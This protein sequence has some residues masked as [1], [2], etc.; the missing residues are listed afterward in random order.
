METLND[1][2]IEIDDIH[3]LTSEQLTE[4]MEVVL[5]QMDS[6]GSATGYVRTKLKDAIEQLGGG[7]SSETDLENLGADIAGTT[8]INAT[9]GNGEGKTP[10]AYS[11]GDIFYIGNRTTQSEKFDGRTYYVSNSDGTAGTSLSDTSKFYSTT[12]GAD[13][14]RMSQDMKKGA[15]NGVASLDEHGFIPQSQVNSI[16]LAPQTLNETQK[17]Q[18]QNNMMGKSYAPAQFSGLGKVYLQKNNG[19]L[20]QEMINQQ[21]TTYVI[22]YDYT[23]TSSITIPNGC[24]LEFD[25]GSFNG[26]SIT[27]GNNI[28]IKGI[29]KIFAD[30][31]LFHS[32]QNLIKINGNNVCIQDIEICSNIEANQQLHSQ[33]GIAI[34][35]YINSTNITIK[36]VHIHDINAGIGLEG[37]TDVSIL[38][39]VI[40]NCFC[41]EYVAS[42]GG[43]DYGYGVI[44]NQSKNVIIKGN[45]IFV[46]RHGLYITLFD[47]GN[48]YCENIVVS[49]NIFEKILAP[50]TYFEYPIKIMPCHNLIFSDNTITNKTLGK[51]IEIELC[52]RNGGDVIISNNVFNVFD[53]VIDLYNTV[54]DNTV[55][56]FNSL[57][58]INNTAE[59]NYQYGSFV[60]ISNID[61][62]T[63][64]GNKI[65]NKNT[66]SEGTAIRLR[67]QE[68]TNGPVSQIKRLNSNNNQFV[69]FLTLAYLNNIDRAT[70]ND[71]IDFSSAGLK[72]IDRYENA[73]WAEVYV[74]PVN[75]YTDYYTNDQRNYYYNLS[76]YDITFDKVIR[77]SPF[78]SNW[79]DANGNLLQ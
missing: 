77:Y 25:G 65:I 48:D 76:Y 37:C 62:I 56:K 68:G 72:P 69:N 50:V 40:E 63:I 36:N 4:R 70:L 18:A 75:V 13:A 74:S 38:D 33:A 8:D 35:C 27:L 73:S 66:A 28:T 15:A 58:V 17:V 60:N 11:K 57:S 53:T 23:L 78:K 61:Y 49:N 12:S 9:E 42:V 24:I 64:S 52:R 54:T 45:R 30:K 14:V 55:K 7:G 5:A 44:P 43:G 1:V 2:G 6:G 46:Q 67:P 51:A 26:N 39:N 16:S 71:S 29:G 41:S 22:Q 79:V 47:D 32:D 31:T 59:L 10:V 3:E 34:Q 20:T 21:N 19:M